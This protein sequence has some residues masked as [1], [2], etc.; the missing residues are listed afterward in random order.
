MFN[1][2]KIS[3]KQLTNIIEESVRKNLAEYRLKQM[4]KSIVRESIESMGGMYQ[5]EADDDDKSDSDN[6]KSSEAKPLHNPNGVSDQNNETEEEQQIRSSVEKFF[7]SANSVGKKVDIAGYAYELD[8][9]KPKSGE[10][11]NEM[12]NS[13]GMFMKKLNHELNDQGYPYSFSTSEI[14]HLASIISSNSKLN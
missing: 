2:M 1:A 9:I 3:E 4:I 6:K 8:G 13:R 11:T 7:K 12:K 14:N 5:F 10:D